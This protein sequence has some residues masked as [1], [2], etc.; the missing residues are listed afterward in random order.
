MRPEP[1]FARSLVAFGNAALGRQ[2]PISALDAWVPHSG[3]VRAISFEEH[4]RPLGA[5]D[6]WLASLGG[7][8]GSAPRLMLDASQSIGCER[9][10]VCADVPLSAWEQRWER[11]AGARQAPWFDARF[12]R[13]ET[14]SV[15]PPRGRTVSDVG[16]SL[17]RALEIGRASGR[18]RV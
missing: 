6:A 18:E 17:E 16:G 11:I 2:V 5:C 4:G 9:V 8:G 12:S 13:A 7:A 10:V 15:L 3:H 14:P 1:P